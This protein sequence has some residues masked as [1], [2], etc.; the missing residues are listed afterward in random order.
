MPELT[1]SLLGAPQLICDTAPISVDT[2]KAI[3]PLAYLA[4]THR[5]QARDALAALLWPEYD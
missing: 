5:P 4:I 3:A 2:R 1:F